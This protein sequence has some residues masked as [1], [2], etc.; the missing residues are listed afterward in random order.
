V[1]ETVD[2]PGLADALTRAVKLPA[3]CG[4]LLDRVESVLAREYLACFDGSH[5]PAGVPWQPLR[6]RRGK[7]LVKSGA[8]RGSGQS[9]RGARGVAYGSDS[10]YA[11][12]QFGGTRTIPARNAVGLGDAA[13]DEVAELAADWAAANLGG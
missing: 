13:A 11:E 1:A 2:L 7:P 6:G 12:Y 3:D 8:L 10:P 4:P 9:R 5:D